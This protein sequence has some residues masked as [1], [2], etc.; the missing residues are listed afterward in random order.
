MA[1]RAEPGG[2]VVV[3]GGGE[4][5]SPRSPIL[6]R[7]ME[8]ASRDMVLVVD[9][10]AH[11]PSRFARQYRQTFLDLGASHVLTPRLESRHDAE[12]G[13]FLE[14]LDGADVV[15][16][17]G[18][19]QERLVSVFRGTRAHDILWERWQRG[20]V[21]VAGT[22]AGASALSRTMIARGEAGMWPRKGLVRLAP[23]L[24]FT[25]VVVDQ[26]FSQ[27]GRLGRLV[28]A[29]LLAQPRVPGVG[30]DENTAVIL[31]PD[32]WAEVVGEGGVALVTADGDDPA[33]W[34][35]HPLQAIIPARVHL[36]TFGDG[37]TFHVFEFPHRSRE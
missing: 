25:A 36:A 31:R 4:D 32:G 33:S 11:Y 26:H 13:G 7:L 34:A 23:G 37:D 9:A 6:R 12:E 3:V 24:G 17:A 21:V 1:R 18:G 14:A 19:D 2:Y 10:A 29:V 16:F 30:V 28:E 15:Y 22:S 27:R 35:D 5:R 20:E 8:L